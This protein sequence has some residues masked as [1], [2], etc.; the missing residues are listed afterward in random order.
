MDGWGNTGPL[1]LTMAAVRA[2]VRWAD[3]R[4]LEAET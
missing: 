3:V 1:G 4:E 2:R